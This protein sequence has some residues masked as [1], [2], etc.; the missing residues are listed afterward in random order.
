[1]DAVKTLL[2]EAPSHHYFSVVYNITRNNKKTI[3]YAGLL[4]QT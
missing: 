1:M 4:K 3:L 2:F